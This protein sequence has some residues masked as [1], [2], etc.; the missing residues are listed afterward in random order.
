MNTTATDHDSNDLGDIPN[1][2]V[3]HEQVLRVASDEL[4]TTLDKLNDVDG[5]LADKLT[6]ICNEMAYF[7]D[8]AERRANEAIRIIENA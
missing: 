7:L 5:D 6:D 4:Q 3:N 2:I 8:Q 1:N